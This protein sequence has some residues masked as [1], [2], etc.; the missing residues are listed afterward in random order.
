MSLSHFFAGLLSR[1]QRIDLF[2]SMNLDLK[3]EDSK[4]KQKQEEKEKEETLNLNTLKELARKD[5][6]DSKD[7]KSE[8]DR[9]DQAVLESRIRRLERLQEENLGSMKKHMTMELK[10][11]MPSQTRDLQHLNSMK[12]VEDKLLT[13]IE[14][15]FERQL[16]LMT[17]LAKGVN[18][19]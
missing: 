2:L 14:Q 5:Y 4:E 15:R 6:L 16:E 18:G 17:Q 11:C 7:E 8:A 10:K 19:D 12:E 1:H 9:V 13:L 3:P